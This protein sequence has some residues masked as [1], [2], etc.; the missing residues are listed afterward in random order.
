MLD[1][2]RFSDY[3]NAEP[4]LDVAVEFLLNHWTIKRP[5]GPCQY[6]IGT[7][8][9]RIEY[10]LPGYNLLIYVHVLSFY[11]YAKR[12]ARFLE[13]LAVLEAKMS[14]GQIVVE[15]VHKKL[16]ALEFCRKGQPSERATRLYHEIVANLAKS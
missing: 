10:P 1:A 11:N 5:I 13:A 7:R 8:F 15:H 9:M 16:A 6:G 3:L 12:D 4:A 2:F 14:G